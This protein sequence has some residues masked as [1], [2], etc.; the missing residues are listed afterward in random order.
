MSGGNLSGTER[1]PAPGRP[2]DPSIEPR[3]VRAAIEELAGHGI[4]GFSVNRVAQ[5][6]EV[7]KRS[8]YSRWPDRRD[9]LTEAL[10]SLVADVRQAETGDLRGDLEKLMP[11]V[12]E[13]FSAP[14]MDILTRALLEAQQDPELYGGFQRDLLDHCAAIVE[15]AFREAARRGELRPGVDPAWATDAFM[16]LLMARGRTPH[17]DRPRSLAAGD[18]AAIIDYVLAT[19]VR[20]PDVAG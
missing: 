8:I 3:V 10:S 14:R 9:L 18:Q 17:R 16:G 4:R 13:V 7:D 11:T 6:A 2:K 20:D 5:R 1:N 19:V 15:H 12:A